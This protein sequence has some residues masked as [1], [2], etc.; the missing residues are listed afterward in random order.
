M[1]AGAL[2]PSPELSELADDLRAAIQALH[3][4]E[5]AARD[6][7]RSGDFG[8]RFVESARAASTARARLDDLRVR[9]DTLALGAE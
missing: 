3:S 2:V 1:R 9:V 5:D 6:C 7:E 8:P 4:V